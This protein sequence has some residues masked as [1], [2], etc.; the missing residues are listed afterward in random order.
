M[1]QLDS[2]LNTVDPLLAFF[3]E[4][5]AVFSDDDFEAMRTDIDRK[6][7]L[8]RI[9]REWRKCRI[10]LDPDFDSERR[11]IGEPPV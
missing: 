6:R 4:V 11:R 3:A 9:Y 2:F 1:A 5:D 7:S 10:E 8:G